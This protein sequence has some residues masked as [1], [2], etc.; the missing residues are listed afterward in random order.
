[1]METLKNKNSPFY[2][3]AGEPLLNMT[4]LRRFGN[5]DDI[6]GAIVFLASDA[7]SY[8]SGAKIVLDGGFTIN[9][10]L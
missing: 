7:S 8:V 9:A 1:M 4:P 6:K 10:G 2:Q 3:L 5:G